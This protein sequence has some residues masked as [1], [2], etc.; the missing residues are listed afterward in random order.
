MRTTCS[1]L[2]CGGS[3]G[4][5]YLYHVDATMLSEARHSKHATGALA[6]FIRTHGFVE[7]REIRLQK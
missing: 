2:V 3:S 5:A 1:T 4:R 7:S 6:K